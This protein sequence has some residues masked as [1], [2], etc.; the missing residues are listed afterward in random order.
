MIECQRKDAH[1]MGSGSESD[2]QAQ[3]PGHPR[4][5]SYGPKDDLLVPNY[6]FETFV[7]YAKVF[8]L[9]FA[10]LKEIQVM[11]TLFV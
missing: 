11:P 2:Y 7:C 5:A 8:T 4:N 1:F 9:P 6:H 3:Q 10:L